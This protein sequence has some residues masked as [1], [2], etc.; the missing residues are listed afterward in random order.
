MTPEQAYSSVKNAIVHGVLVRPAVCGKCGDAPKPAKDGRSRIQAHHH[1]YSKPLDV[2]WL[3]A[4]CHR[5]ETPLPEIMGAPAIGEINGQAKLTEADVISARRLRQKG[6]TFQAIADR[7][8]VH[9]TTIIRA[10]KGQLWGHIAAAPQPPKAAALAA[11]HAE[12]VRRMAPMTENQIHHAKFANSD[13]STI[14]FARAIEQHH[15]IGVKP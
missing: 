5:E 4:K 11:D 12:D 14:S 13:G 6:M 3:C 10:V 8:G 7:I 2:E 9:K 1:D 15:G